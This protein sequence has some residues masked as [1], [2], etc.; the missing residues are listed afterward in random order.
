MGR[1][2]GSGRLRPAPAAPVRPRRTPPPSGRT[3]GA[4]DDRDRRPGGAHR[5]DLL[6]RAGAGRPAGP[7]GP[8]PP[9]PR[10]VEH[11]AVRRR[12]GGV[13]G[14]R[15]VLH[16]AAVDVP[17]PGPR[18]GR[19]RVHRGP[20]P[21]PDRHR[22]RHLSPREPATAFPNIPSDHPAR[23]SRTSPRSPEV[24]A[25]PPLPSRPPPRGCRSRTRSGG[26]ANSATGRCWPAGWAGS[27]TSPSASR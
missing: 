10:P 13:R 1:R 20:R 24:R 9:G 2:P 7:A 8:Q 14:D 23:P 16:P 17:R 11:R 15:P 18:P 25:C 6:V 19:G 5:P 27:A 12:R 3:A 22:P 4:L 26:C 21:L